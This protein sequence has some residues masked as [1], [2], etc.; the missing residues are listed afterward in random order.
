MSERKGRLPLDV[1]RI[2]LYAGLILHWLPAFVYFDENFVGGVWRAYAGNAA[3]YLGFARLPYAAAI[4]LA[5]LTFLALIAGLCG[6]LPRLVAAVSFAGLFVFHQV[7]SLTTSAMALQIAFGLLIVLAVSGAGA[8]VWRWGPAWALG[9]KQGRNE[10]AATIA[11]AVYVL[12]SIFYAGIEKCLSG[13]LAGNRLH[14]I[15]SSPEGV[16]V[17][18]WV[19]NVSWL[20]APATGWWL[21]LLTLG[22][23]LVAPLAVLWRPTRFLAALALAAAFLAFFAVLQ[24]PLLFPMVYLPLFLWLASTGSRRRGCYDV[25]Q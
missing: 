9:P 14:A 24:L 23:E 17:R 3:I 13:W 2:G 15:L 4:G 1:V 16:Y 10:N 8:A 20:R 21:G 12:S 11:V 19:L 25:C 6:I 22:I 18:D 7:N 5:G